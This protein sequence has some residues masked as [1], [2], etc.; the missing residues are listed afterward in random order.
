MDDQT[1]FFVTNKMTQFEN[2]LQGD[3]QRA[4]DGKTKYRTNR[5]N[6]HNRTVSR[7]EHKNNYKFANARRACELRRAPSRER[8][9]LRPKHFHEKWK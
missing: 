9:H 7:V 3:R 1:N 2:I 6:E 5:P 4:C 8:F